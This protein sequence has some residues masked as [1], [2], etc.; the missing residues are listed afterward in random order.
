MNKM[1]VVLF[2]LVISAS[3]TFAGTPMTNQGTKALSFQFTG[4][5]SFGVGDASTHSISTPL[6]TASIAGF[7]GKY[8]LSNDMEL[9]GVLAFNMKTDQSKDGA[10]VDNGKTTTTDFGLAPALLWHMTASGSVSP[11][12]GIGAEFAWT[13]TTHTPQPTGNESSTSGTAFGA[14]GI[15]GAEWWAWDNLSFNAE[16][17]L[18]FTTASGKSDVGGTSVDGP[19]T[20]NVGISSFW[21]GINVYLGQ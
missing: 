17:Q 20:T 12:W 21:M 6:G 5:G 2:V 13:K 11:Y 15:L 1:L 8:Y 9:R 4:L 10:G 14:A 18:A 7:G 3:L 16:Y 19:S